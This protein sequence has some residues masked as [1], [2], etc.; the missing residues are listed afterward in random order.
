MK[1]VLVGSIK[2]IILDLNYVKNKISGRRFELGAEPA[3]LDDISKHL[4]HI[5]AIL[6]RLAPHFNGFLLSEDNIF[7]ELVRRTNES[8]EFINNVKRDEVGSTKRTSDFLILIDNY[9]DYIDRQTP[10][11]EI[12][13]FPYEEKLKVLAEY[14]EKKLRPEHPAHQ[15]LKTLGENMEALWKQGKDARSK[16][17]SQIIDD[18]DALSR[19]H[20]GPSLSELDLHARG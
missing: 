5:Q 8:I 2:E 10:I 14:F 15:R 12:K 17:Y 18:L 16:Q 7:Y 4:W 1:D 20:N 11:E 19:S 6:N 3:E 13:I 9:L